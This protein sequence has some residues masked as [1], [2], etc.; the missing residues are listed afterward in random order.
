MRNTTKLE[1]WLFALATSVLCW[2]AIAF[3]GVEPC[4][5]H[6]ASNRVALPQG[7]PGMKPQRA[8][9]TMAQ[10][11][12]AHARMGGATSQITSGMASAPS[13]VGIGFEY[14]LQQ[15]SFCNCGC[16]GDPA[17]D[18]STDILDVVGTVNVA[19]RNVAAYTMLT[20]Q[21]LART[22]TDCSGATDVIDVVH[23]VN[24]AFRNGN[25]ATEFCSPCQQ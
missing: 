15:A 12:A 21:G 11:F 3:S 9:F 24:V 19:F 23:M 10:P 20:C 4:P 6:A 18:G 22:D 25:P 14:A 8:I 7:N 1:R 2:S 5:W 13:Q 16:L 17:C